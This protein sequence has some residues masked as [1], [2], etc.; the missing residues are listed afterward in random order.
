MSSRTATADDVLPRERVDRPE[1]DCGR[2][3]DNDGP[4]SYSLLPPPASVDV[5]GFSERLGAGALWRRPEV[6][7]LGGAW[8]DWKWL[9]RSIV[10]VRIRMEGASRPI[11]DE[12]ALGLVR[13][14]LPITE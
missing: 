11:R 1:S 14:F 13:C 5:D 9:L 4:G 2:D 3:D 10:V 8:S 6:V 7:L 12:G